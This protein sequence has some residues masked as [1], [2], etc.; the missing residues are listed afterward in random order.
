MNSAQ[1][2][3]RAPRQSQGFTCACEEFLIYRPSHEQNKISHHD[4]KVS[5]SY[6]TRS[7]LQI[8]RYELVWG[9]RVMILWHRTTHEFHP[10]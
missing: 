6:H 8:L 7:R 5:D 3:S 10:V 9:F 4:M 2:E 1:S